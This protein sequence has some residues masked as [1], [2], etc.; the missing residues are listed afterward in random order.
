MH[1]VVGLLGAALVA[2]NLAEFFV[3]IVLPRRVK[4]S[5]RLARRVFTVTWIPARALARRLSSRTADT[6]LGVFGPLGLFAILALWTVGVILG[7]AALQWAGGSHVVPHRSGTFFDDLYFSGGAFLSASGGTSPQN[8]FS[9]VVLLLEAGT[10]LMILFIVI[11]YLPALYEAFSRRE[12]VVSQLDPRAGS[13]PSAGALLMRSADRGG[14][15][16]IATYLDEWDTWTAELM[17]THLSYPVLAYYRSQH[18][19]QNWLTALTA[20]VDTSAFAM[21]AAPAPAAHAGELT[22]AIGRHALA[23]LAYTFRAE[24]RGP[25]EE[26]L[27]RETLSDLYDDLAERD[28]DLVD[29]DLVRERLTQLRSTYEPYANALS[30]HL[31]V[32]LPSWMPRDDAQRNWEE[33]LWQSRRGVS[34]L[35]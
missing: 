13:P 9:K 12:V 23:D 22:F 20:A 16:E 11:G 28:L 17:E 15:E 19:N 3:M 35:P 27:P 32:P 34:S 24:P 31:A 10:G 33:A 14:W 4:R 18:V 1:V 21:A 25:G 7:F 26:R 30:Q 29:L 2:V 5:V 8:A 6:F